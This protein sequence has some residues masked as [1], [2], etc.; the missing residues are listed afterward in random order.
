MAAYLPIG[1]ADADHS[2][3]TMDEGESGFTQPWAMYHDNLRRLWLN[4]KYTVRREPFG[5]ACMKITREADGWHVDASAVESGYQWGE[6][7]FVGGSYPI[8][9]ASVVF[10][11]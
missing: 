10:S 11:R 8:A 2:I 4:G 9:V 5:T 3:A 6:D 7:G 1:K